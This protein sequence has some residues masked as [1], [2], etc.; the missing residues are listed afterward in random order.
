MIATPLL[1]LLAAGAQL[2]DLG[3]LPTAAVTVNEGARE[4]VVELPPI[5]LPAHAGHHGGGGYPP[6]VRVPMPIDAAIYGFRVD[7]VGADGARLPAELLHHFNLIDPHNRE[8]FL[9]ISRRVL[10]AGKETGEQ[11]L[12]WFLFGMPVRQGAEWVAN[13][14]LHN[15]TDTDYAGVR[16]RL[17]LR[18]VPG[19]RPW[20]LWE[21]YAFQLDVAFPVGD[22]S[23]T[24]PPGK[25]SRSYE[26]RPSVPGRIVAVG[27]H[28]HELGTRIELVEV[29]TGKV[30]WSASPEL[31]AEK[32]VV[33]I[34]VGKLYGWFRIGAPVRSDRTYRVTV[35]Y[36][37]PTGAPI[38]AGGMGV[39]G[40]LFVPDRGAVW[41]SADTSLALYRQD[42]AHYLRLAEPAGAPAPADPHA[43]HRHP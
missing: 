10:A 30:L 43:E 14:M 19:S 1:A 17:V 37:N 3:T 38:E 23:F 20:P 41:P 8:L 9:P 22:K 29:E 33:G 7:V 32:N 11:R 39:L 5:D 36:D 25:S 13:A 42:A 6:V 27:G 12:P 31:D 28:L 18:Y 35:H 40:G 16:T 34:P 24:L 4:I 2:P 21:G 26:A 15:P